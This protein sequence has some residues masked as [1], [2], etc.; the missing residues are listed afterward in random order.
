MLQELGGIGGTPDVGTNDADNSGNSVL[1]AIE[2]IGL[3]FGAGAAAIGLN[4][5]AK[6]T[7]TAP[8]VPAY[9][10]GASLRYGPQQIA[11]NAAVQA[12]SAAPISN[13]TLFLGGGALLLGVVLIAALLRR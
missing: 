5:L 4:A 11:Y 10:S 13:T 8:Q 7:G 6:S 3:N 1:S 12:R 9:S 2:N